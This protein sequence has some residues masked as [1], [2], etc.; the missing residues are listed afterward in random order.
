M[1]LMSKWAVTMVMLE[2]QIAVS[3]REEEEMSRGVR[4]EELKVGKALLRLSNL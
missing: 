4:M 2:V 1:G 3:Q